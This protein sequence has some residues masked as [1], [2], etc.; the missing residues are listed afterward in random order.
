[1]I[2]QVGR[3]QFGAFRVRTMG[4][5]VVTLHSGAFGLASECGP[6]RA[7]ILRRD[8]QIPPASTSR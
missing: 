3:A 2:T 1:M 8:F 6:M 7:Y 5:A 4:P